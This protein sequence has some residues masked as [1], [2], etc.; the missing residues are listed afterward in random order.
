[1]HN[2]PVR[3]DET[4]RQPSAPKAGYARTKPAVSHVVDILNAIEED[5]L[6]GALAPGERL[7][8]RTLAERFGVSRTPVREAIQRLSAGGIVTLQARHGATVVRLDIADIFDAFTIVSEL[9]ALG[10]AQAAR[11][12]RPEQRSELL[13][14]SEA[15]AA[16]AGSGDHEG[17]NR[18]NG[19]LHD[20]ILAASH[21][22]ILACQLRTAQL[23]TAPYRRSITYQPGRMAASIGEH[24]AIVQAIL[25]SD[26]ETAAREMRRHVD[27]L[28]VGAG[29]VIHHLRLSART[30]R[31]G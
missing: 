30:D 11:R 9:E 6:S 12:I 31:T 19:R 3:A 16:A 21:N 15:C 8:E 18:A 24:A 23:L 7:D 28:A 17:F 2:S 5:I 22:R 1:M 20:A 10:A 26:G 25:E 4:G 14:A 29:D 13:E 27:Q